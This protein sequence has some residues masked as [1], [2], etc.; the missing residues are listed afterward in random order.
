MRNNKVAIRKSYTRVAEYVYIES[1]MYIQYDDVLSYTYVLTYD[2]M[3]CQS[4]WLFAFIEPSMHQL[5]TLEI[6]QK[7]P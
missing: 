1:S 5:G 2:W 4:M 6:R 3:C 7:D